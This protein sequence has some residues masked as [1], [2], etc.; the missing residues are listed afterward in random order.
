MSW[1]GARHIVSTEKPQTTMKFNKFLSHHEVS[2]TCNLNDASDIMS[3]GTLVCV[4]VC[5]AYC[6]T[7]SAKG[8]NDVLFFGEA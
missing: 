1:S 8:N 5:S 3:V 2:G 4:C 7:V 6:R